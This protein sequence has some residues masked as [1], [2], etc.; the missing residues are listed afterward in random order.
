MLL[1][2]YTGGK[3]VLADIAT[4]LP[5]AAFDLNEGPLLLKFNAKGDRLAVGAGN[6]VQVWDLAP[7]EPKRL[8]TSDPLPAGVYLAAFAPDGKS[9]TV[10]AAHSVHAVDVGTGRVLWSALAHEA[11]IGTVVYAPDGARVLTAPVRGD[12]AVRVWDAATGKETAVLRHT[13]A[14][15]NAYSRGDGREIRYAFFGV[16]PGTVVTGTTDGAIHLWDAATGARINSRKARTDDPSIVFDPS[17]KTFVAATETEFRVYDTSALTRAAF[18]PVGDAVRDPAPAVRILAFVPVRATLPW[19]RASAKFL[20]YSADGKRLALVDSEMRAGAWDV[21]TGRELNRFPVYA[22]D[23]LG[24]ALSHDGKRL[25]FALRDKTVGLWDVDTGTEVQKL[26]GHTS[27]VRCAAFSPDGKWLATGNGGFDTTELIL[28]HAPTG[29]KVKELARGG[30]WIDEIAFAPDS[31]W[32]VAGTSRDG[33]VFEVSSGAERFKLDH[34]DSASRVAVSGDGRLVALGG[35]ITS[36]NSLHDVTVW[37]AATGKLLHTLSGHARTI[38][39]LAFG[40]GGALVVTAGD[41]FLWDATTGRLLRRTAPLD[42]VATSPDGATLAGLGAAGVNLTDLAALRDDRANAALAPVLAL[43]GGVASEPG[44]VRVTLPVRGPDSVA[45]LEGL[46]TFPGPLSLSLDRPDALPDA[47]VRAI[48]ELKTLRHLAFNCRGLTDGQLKVVAGLPNLEELDLAECNEVAPAG[49]MVLAKLERLQTLSLAGTQANAE[50]L[51]SL[52]GLKG[53]RSLN[54]RYTTVGEDGISAL[55]KFPALADLTLSFGDAKEAAKLTE[56][57][58]LRRLTLASEVEPEAFPH[59]ARLTDLEELDLSFTS[60]DDSALAHLKGLTNLRR[61][62]LSHTKVSDAGLAHLKGLTKLNSLGLEGLETVTGTGLAHLK[63]ATALTALQLQFTGVTDDGLAGLKEWVHLKSLVLPNRIADAGP[64][65]LGKLTQLEV[66]N[67]NALDKVT[68]PG[69]AGLKD[70][71]IRGLDL[72]QGKMTDADLDGLKGWKNLQSLSLPKAVTDAGLA[73][74]TGLTELRALRVEGASGMTDAGLV[75]LKG[76]TKLAEL[77]LRGTKVT[78]AGLPQLLPL[79]ALRHVRFWQS[80]VT[81]KGIEE[82]QK[83]MPDAYLNR[84]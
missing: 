21:A 31:S 76:L 34:P 53:L 67:L 49:L 64:L 40:A 30:G 43:G 19:D 1:A 26:V 10:A 73:K 74:L 75:H 41:T 8:V 52:A 60:A 5:K 38:D 61:L 57:K 32:L 83:Q 47:A 77:D 55:A 3:L 25:A 12:A 80:G 35:G 82:F 16:D 69:L 9:I 45:A 36:W 81:D 33:R 24:V 79:Q 14:F 62:N 27:F 22:G 78:D 63:G 2:R 42:R 17:G 28:W 4:G 70:S 51:R 84:F 59:L 58:S 71:R 29:T 6:Q 18:A 50:T 7:A 44:G 37:D 20:A 13:P 11:R 72:S 68:G 48:G 39:G 66:V 46:K 23:V 65:H 56:V 15:E 54:L